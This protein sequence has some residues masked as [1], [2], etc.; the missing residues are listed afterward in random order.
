MVPALAISGLVYSEMLG[1]R[2]NLLGLL[3]EPRLVFKLLFTVLLVAAT[4][5]LAMRLMR[6]TQSA[7]GATI[8]L[9]ALIMVLIGAIALELAIL[10]QNA[11]MAQLIGH[12]ATACLRSIP[13]LALAPFAAGF[14]GLRN[15]APLRPWLAGAGIGLFAGAIGA[16]LYATHCPD[17]S[18]LFVAT[19]Y[20]LGIAAVTGAGALLGARYF[21]W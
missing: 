12:N 21:K 8:A 5:I 18:P 15:G 19:W 3:N 10:P 16:L 17:D 11:W 20:S 7:R 1:I 9:L 4:S 6:P 13:L 14:V 2:P